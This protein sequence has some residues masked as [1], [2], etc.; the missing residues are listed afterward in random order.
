MVAEGMVT[1][2]AATVK[3]PMKTN[4]KAKPLADGLTKLSESN[5]RQFMK[6]T[7]ETDVSDTGGEVA[8]RGIRTLFA[9]QPRSLRF[10]LE[11]LTLDHFC[12]LC[13]N[14]GINYVNNHSKFQCRK[15]LQILASFQKQRK[16]HGLILLTA[17]E[18]SGRNIVQLVND[19]FS[20]YFFPSAIVEI[21]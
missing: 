14:C 13:K 12:K 2:D 19:I 21:E 15:A 17:T 5:F 9:N 3:P 4:R 16:R 1:G 8:V 20:N 18:R 6:F 7:M 10:V 11:K